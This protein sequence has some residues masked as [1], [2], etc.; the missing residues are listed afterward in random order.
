MFIFGAHIP[1]KQKDTGELEETLFPFLLPHEYVAKIVAK[2]P[3]DHFREHL[4]TELAAQLEKS[5]KGLRL[6]CLSHPA[7]G[8]A[9]GWCVPSEAWRY[10]VLLLE[11]RWHSSF[12][13][14]LEHSGGQAAWL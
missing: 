6:V 9:W 7:G 13:A 1:L 5:C 4:P 14:H 3:L 12:C 10:R 2:K 8:L 11:L